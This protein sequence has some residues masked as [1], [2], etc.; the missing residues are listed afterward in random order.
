MTKDR[1]DPK[2]LI[3]LTLIGILTVALLWADVHVHFPLG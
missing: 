3:V 1:F 2:L